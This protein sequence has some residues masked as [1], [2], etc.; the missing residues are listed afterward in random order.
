MT[1]GFYRID[2]D[3][4]FHRALWVRAPDY[5]LDYENKDE[6]EYPTPGGWVWFNTRDE[7]C[8]YF[9]LD[10]GTPWFGEDNDPA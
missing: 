10:P 2:Q 6:Y 8:L 9:N 5:S 7:A 1:E 3:G 4:I